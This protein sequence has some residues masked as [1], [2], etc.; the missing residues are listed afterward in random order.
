MVNYRLADQDKKELQL[1][2]ERMMGSVERQDW[3]RAA[4]Y[5][6][7]CAQLCQLISTQLPAMNSYQYRERDYRRMS[8]KY[9]QLAGERVGLWE[10]F[11]VW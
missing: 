10:R 7:A 8:V 2:H 3:K 11:S 6:E 9:R 5:A 1:M 4:G